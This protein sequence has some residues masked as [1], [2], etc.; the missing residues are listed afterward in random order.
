MG[1]YCKIGLVLLAKNG[2]VLFVKLV[3][4]ML[5][6]IELKGYYLQ[7]WWDIFC[8]KICGIYLGYRH[9]L[10]NWCAIIGQVNAIVSSNFKL[11][12]G[13]ETN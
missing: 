1:Y 2:R 12:K 10:Q 9:Y 7:N 13:R 3:A 4:I 6:Y 5:Y 8:C 11:C